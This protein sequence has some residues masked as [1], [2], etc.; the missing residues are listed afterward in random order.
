MI[1]ASASASGP[2]DSG[3]VVT[4]AEHAEYQRLRRAATVRHR[5]ARRAGATVLLVLTLL[6]APL[7]LVATWVHDQV[8]DTDRYV[9]TVAPLA[10]DPHV[11]QVVIDRLTDRVVAQVDV[12]A[13][14]AAL[15]R[16]LAGNGAPPRVVDGARSLTA[17]LRS[18]VRTV[19]HR[20]V[21]RVV[22]GEAFQQA[23]EGANRRAHA[24]VLTMLTGDRDGAVR[25][26][27]DTVLLDIGVVVDQVRQRL[28]DAGFDK[29]AAI[30]DSDRTVP[31]FRTAQLGR[32]QDAMRLLD[33]AGTWLPVLTLT[34]GAL[35]VW[36]APGHRVM[37]MITALGVGLTAVVLLVALVVLRRV[38]L[39][40][41]PP[42]TL[43]PDAAAAIFDTFVRFLRAS[44]R[45]LL[46][47]CLLTALTA[48]LYGPGRAARGA[49]T[50]ALRG[51]SA[52]GHALRRA[53]VTTGL[54]GHWLSAHR[55]WTTGVTIGAGAFA[56]VLRN[57]PTV[58]AVALVLVLI[59]VV[60]AI[61]AVLAAAQPAR[62][63]TDRPE[64]AAA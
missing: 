39:D 42:A 25:A 26:E 19:V 62:D 14:T 53:G 47:V 8:S 54:T 4:A 30:P 28:V 29:A 34:L 37:V 52:A 45:T 32:A 38:Y 16:T 22:T 21:S 63:T 51:T 35:A 33:I 27:G 40:S 20:N 64:H 7:A 3:H 43:P 23:W 12:E 1:P 46:V 6:L 11:Q 57:H 59:L 58:G 55:R 61:T 5:R 17:P 49:R 44:A 18:A 31:L 15:T 41:V 2:S 13:I 48:W 24:T 36:A 60:L 10:S 50:L 56:L 9:R